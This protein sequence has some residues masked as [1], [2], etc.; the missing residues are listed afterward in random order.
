[1]KLKWIFL[2]FSLLC[3]A[4]SQLS[5]ASN[6]NDKCLSLQLEIQ[7]KTNHILYLSFPS[8]TSTNIQLKTLLKPK[9]TS[10][11]EVSITTVKIIGYLSFSIDL[12][13]GKSIHIIDPFN[14]YQGVFSVMP[15]FGSEDLQITLNHKT[16]TDPSQGTCLFVNA[17]TISIK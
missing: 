7:N 3:A 15:D 1:M 5:A 4:T 13:I 12:G 6:T 8:D 2:A 17:A 16:I 9:E 10:T 14:T 11:L